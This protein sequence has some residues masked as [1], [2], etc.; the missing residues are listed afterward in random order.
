MDQQLKLTT[1][2]LDTFIH[3]ADTLSQLFDYASQVSWALK[4]ALLET[5]RMRTEAKSRAEPLD[6]NAFIAELIKKDSECARLLENASLKRFTRGQLWLHANNGGDYAMLHFYKDWIMDYLKDR[7]GC[8]F[9]V[10]IKH[11]LTER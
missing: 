5:K 11:Q 7:F 8:T 6:W 1:G 2:H 9:R 10:R 3:W 4:L